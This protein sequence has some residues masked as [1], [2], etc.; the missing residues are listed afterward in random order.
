MVIIMTEIKGHE[1]NGH[2]DKSALIKTSVSL[3]PYLYEWLKLIVDN[4]TFNSQSSAM[5]TALA[6][7]KGHMEEREALKKAEKSEPTS[8][9]EPMKLLLMFLTEYPEFVEKINRM[10]IK[11]GDRENDMKKVKFE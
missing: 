8:P 7:M 6:E 2:E 10:N 4:K 9:D 11:H 1:D 3:P 5:V